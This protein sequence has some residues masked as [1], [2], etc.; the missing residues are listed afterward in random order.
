MRG[1]TTADVVPA[2]QEPGRG[3]GTAAASLAT[4]IAVGTVLA[5]AASAAQGDPGLTVE[6][7]IPV[8]LW[9]AQ[10]AAVV[11][12]VAG[13]WAA[14]T[15]PAPTGI[16][17]AVAAAGALLPLWAAW[18]W[19]PSPA[20]AG[21]LAAAPLTVAGTVL[22]G[23][24]SPPGAG[25]S[26][27]RL[28]A[29]AV[30]LLAGTASA[31]HLLGYNPLADP[32]CART[33]AEVRPVLEA[34]VT[35]RT[36]VAATG[37]LT[38]VAAGLGAFAVLSGSAGPRPPDGVAVA[39][40]AALSV[41]AGSPVIQWARW[42]D[43][44]PSIFRMVV[45]PFAVAAVGVALCARW[46]GT[47]RVRAA[48]DRLVAGLSGPEA[49]LG[50]LGGAIRGVQFAIPEDTRWVDAAGRDVSE[51][52]ASTR[53]LVLSDSSGPV[54]RLV[55]AAQ[56]ERGEVLAALTPSTRL[57]L[58]NAQ[59]TVLVQHRVAEVQ[60]SQRRVVAAAD[61]ERRRIERDLHD[62][63]QQHLVG[64]SF[65]LRVAM[66]RVHPDQAA[67]LTAAEAAVRDALAHL[68]RLAHG[69]FPAVLTEE[70]LAGALHELVADCTV[71]AALDV[72]LDEDLPVHV[73]MAAYAAVGAALGVVAG[74]STQTRAHISAI[75][76]GSTLAVQVRV[77]GGGEAVMTTELSDAADRVGAL[78][79]DLT[80]HATSGP[81]TLVTVVIPCES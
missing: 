75:R 37:L 79:G 17:V 12:I 78:G 30:L 68:R 70:G 40:L 15:H 61:A 39:V 76:Q 46:V 29:V 3:T 24:R 8:W 35:T 7:N 26:T 56:A 33:C 49:A 63:A 72:D 80:L 9:V 36:A 20:R 38:I 55:L 31:V 4:A 65:H 77:H 14:R 21:L 64:A 19:L 16:G 28:T 60:A 22:V 5:S 27:A 81:E 48:V 13:A 62:G 54:L 52:P 34:V 43:P 47:V 44:T 25:A 10:L 1:V 18:S 53:L 59:L 50:D 69:I 2:Q 23:L 11:T 73:A 32:A 6:R 58:R 45:A 66:A 51:H 41:L 57:A 42:G 74:A 71:P 67:G